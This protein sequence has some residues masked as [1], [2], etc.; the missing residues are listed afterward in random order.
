MEVS[1]SENSY[2]K[3]FKIIPPSHQLAKRYINKHCLNITLMYT[4][5]KIKFNRYLSNTTKI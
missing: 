2:K 4:R 3:T 5:Q 1:A